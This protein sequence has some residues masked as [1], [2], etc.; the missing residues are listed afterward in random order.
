MNSYTIKI[1]DYDL[2]LRCDLTPEALDEIVKKVDGY[3]TGM[4]ARSNNI[5]KTEAAILC[6]LEFCSACEQVEQSKDQN[7]GEREKLVEENKKAAAQIARLESRL[8]AQKERYEA[9]AAAQK[10]RSDAAVQTQKEKYEGRIENMK[11][12]YET[13]IAQLKAKVDELRSGAAQQMSID[14]PAD[15]NSAVASATPA[16]AAGDA[17]PAVETAAPVAAAGTAPE[18]AE[19]AKAEAAPAAAAEPAKTE[20]TETPAKKSKSKVGSMFELLTYGDV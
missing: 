13:R 3:I 8:E 2:R 12:K 4:C 20:A 15:E 1:A 18:A 14:I 19:S 17:A 5:S 10:E 9:A 6:A 11:E 16:P 7:N